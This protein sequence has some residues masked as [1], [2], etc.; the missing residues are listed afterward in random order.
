VRRKR[1]QPCQHDIETLDTE[2]SLDRASDRG[3]AIVVHFADEP[4]RDV[5]V[6]RSHP[7]GGRTPPERLA[8]RV[9]DFR[10]AQSDGLVELDT[11]EEAHQIRFGFFVLGF[12]FWVLRSRVALLVV[13]R[14]AKPKTENPKPKTENP[15]PKT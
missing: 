8:K 5:E 13:R 2:R 14:D 4:E 12:S 7:P 15:K 10:R 3:S 9:R 1:P 6:P 11:D